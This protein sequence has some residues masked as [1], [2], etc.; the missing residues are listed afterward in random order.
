[1]FMPRASTKNLTE[2]D[3]FQASK[4]LLRRIGAEEKGATA[5]EYA[6]MAAFIGA[7]IASTVWALGED[8]KTNLY[9]KLAAML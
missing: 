9:N 3:M 8:I 6:L 2:A 1:M 5:I 7:V 4:A